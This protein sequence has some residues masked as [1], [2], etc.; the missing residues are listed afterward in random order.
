MASVSLFPSQSESDPQSTPQSQPQIGPVLASTASIVKELLTLPKESEKELVEKGGKVIESL[1]A[2]RPSDIHIRTD[3]HPRVQVAGE[4]V[5][6]GGDTER[7][8]S[9]HV[10]GILLALWRSRTGAHAPNA[11]EDSHKA[12]EDEFRTRLRDDKVV[13]FACE[14]GTLDT[15]IQVPARLRVQAFLDQNGPGATVRVLRDEIP[16]LESLAFD[17][18]TRGQ[19]QSLVIRRSGLCLVTGQTGAGKSTTLA[20]LINWLRSHHHRHIVT[21]EQPIEF[22]YPDT[23]NGKLCPSLIT[24]QEV[25][26][27]VKDF[28]TGLESALRKAPHGILV[29]EI[30][31]AETMETAL[32]AAETGH[33]VFGTLHT[34]TAPETISRITS[35]FPPARHQGVLGQLRDSLLFVLSQG[36]LPR[37]NATDR[38]LCYEFFANSDTA[39][40]AAIGNFLENAT[41]L[42]SSLLK[43]GNTSWD[44]KLHDLHSTGLIS[45][46]VRQANIIATEESR[47]HA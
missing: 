37:K 8:S 33:I 38:V 44:R 17:E 36:L 11:T 15:I 1:L 46:E 18:T 28:R 23:T 42:N 10:V 21:I 13:D 22:R 29:G 6:A 25:G 43:Q 31:D 2:L 14:G 26:M 32:T 45:D 27:H 12:V 39:T 7:L 24:Q 3:R 41:T 20:A 34:R 4:L 16:T 5:I 35:F 47:N 9:H 19:M 40:K 30:R